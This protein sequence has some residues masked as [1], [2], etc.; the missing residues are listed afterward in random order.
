[1]GLVF[2]AVSLFLVN[3]G[4]FPLPAAKSRA[5]GMGILKQSK[6]LSSYPMARIHG[7]DESLAGNEKVPEGSKTMIW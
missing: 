3:C 6:T 1:M 5:P 2:V 4:V 7:I